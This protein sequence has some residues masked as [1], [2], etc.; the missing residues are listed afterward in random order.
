MKSPWSSWSRSSSALIWDVT[1]GNQEASITALCRELTCWACARMSASTGSS[2][3]TARYFGSI[4]FYIVGSCPNPAK[5]W[6]YRT[7]PQ[8]FLSANSI[9]R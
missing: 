3:P 8:V 5:A 7:K 4:L 9:R 6:L 1:I 2:M